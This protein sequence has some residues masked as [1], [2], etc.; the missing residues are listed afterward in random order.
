MNSL[1]LKVELVELYSLKDFVEQNYKE[2]MLVNLVV[3][4][5]FVNIVNYSN[6]DYIIVNI[7]YYDD[8]IIEFV[9]NGIKFDPTSQEAPKK[10]NDIEE[11]QLGGVGI[12][13]AKSYADEL[14]YA[15]EN[16]ENH[17]KIIKKGYDE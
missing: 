7:E 8:L 9:D 13:L 2:D 14:I 11:A 5:I 10:P 17:L 15:Y 6:A 12:L 1:K 16:G 3:E 4:E